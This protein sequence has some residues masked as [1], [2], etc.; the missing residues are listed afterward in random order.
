MMGLSQRIVPSG[1]RRAS[2]VVRNSQTGWTAWQAPRSLRP[3]LMSLST[4]II[5]GTS[6]TC[7]SLLFVFLLTRKQSYDA[8]LGVQLTGIRF[9]LKISKPILALSLS[10]ASRQ[11]PGFASQDLPLRSL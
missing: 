11:V 9:Y 10:H 8:E 4:T 3:D 6:W 2:E 5:C 1:T 7:L